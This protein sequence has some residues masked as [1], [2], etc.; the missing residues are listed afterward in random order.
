MKTKSILLLPLVLILCHCSAVSGREEIQSPDGNVTVTCQTDR[1][2]LFYSIQYRGKQ[3]IQH[4]PLGLTVK[5][6]GE[7]GKGLVLQSVDKDSADETWQPVWGNRS[8]IQNKYHEMHLVYG[9]EEAPAQLELVF[10]AY[11]DGVAF[12]YLLPEGRVKDFNLTEEKTEFVFPRDVTVWA[13]DY[14][15]FRSHQEEVFIKQKLSNL[16]DSAYI[17]CP[18]LVQ[19]DDSV[20]A[21][22]MEANLTDWAGLYFTT[23]NAPA[24]G[25]RALLSPRLD[26]SAV[27]VRG[28][29]PAPSPWRVVMVGQQPG[30]LIESE[31]VYNL[32]EPCQIEDPSW[33]EPGIAAWDRWW[34]GSYAPDY[35]GTLGMDT[36]SMKYFIDF[37]A[38]MGW[39][40]QLVDW[41]W[42]GEPFDTTQALG[43]AGNPDANILQP[44]P[45]ID[46]PE[47][48][49]YGRERGVKILLWLDCFAAARQM[50]TAFPLFE[51]WGVAGVK[52]D[53]MTR[54][55]QDMVNWYHDLVKLAAAHHLIVDFHGAY[56]PTGIERTW[57]NLMTREGV[58]GNEHNKWSADITPEHTLT[59]PFT[60]MLCGPMDFTPGGFINRLEKDF[61]VVGGDAPA[62]QVMGTRCH[63]LAMMIVY[64]SPLQ[65]MCDSPYNY[66]HSPDGL[67]FLKV[68]PTTWEDT[69]VI[70]GQPGEFIVVARRK[71]SD[72]Y[73]GM[74]N[75]EGMRSGELRL[76]FL[77]R[78]QYTVRVWHDAL[79][80]LT[81][82]ATYSELAV[83]QNDVFP[84]TLA[85][86][87]GL[88]MILQSHD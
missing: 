39:E 10:R 66:R 61:Q 42:Y 40:Y 79:N 75:A 1:S 16:P 63:Q 48:V 24:H 44:A 20:W 88:V 78:N 2:G 13:A 25:V 65:V 58:K 55:D 67:D 9:K 43:A 64:E 47:L 11:N 56:K 87:G 46:I 8:Q 37:A 86:E 77:E 59:L 81:E 54:D 6:M 18:L 41:H 68:V 51:S 49:R 28:T 29:A 36:E 17:G 7:L 72:W 22:L 3:I 73:V 70:A 15:S 30:D 84:F 26:D 45:L 4:A 14:G 34:C 21:A 57:P 76:D 19:I 12:R 38:E 80:G 82:K 85:E 83:T 69:R 62:P 52:V 50:E 71:G 74:M 31:L 33:I 53:F 27:L 5:E 60:R 23:R 35:P 32:N